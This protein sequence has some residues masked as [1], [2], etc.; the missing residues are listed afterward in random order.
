[1]KDSPSTKDSSSSPLLKLYTKRSSEAIIAIMNTAFP[2]MGQFEYTHITI[3]HK[4]FQ[5]SL[6]FLDF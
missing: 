6:T 1:M 5:I 3:N 2:P 4:R